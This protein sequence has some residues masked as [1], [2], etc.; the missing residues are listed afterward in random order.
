MEPGSLTLKSLL[1][2]YDERL[3]TDEKIQFK[4]KIAGKIYELWLQSV[5][6]CKGKSNEKIGIFSGSNEIDVIIQLS[7]ISNIIQLIRE[8]TDK[9]YTPESEKEK[10]KSI[11]NSS[12]IDNETNRFD[13][14]T[15][16]HK[17]DF[18]L[19][20]DKNAGIVQKERETMACLINSSS[21][22]DSSS[23][24]SSDSSSDSDSCRRKSKS[25]SKSKCVSK[26]KS[27]SKQ[28]IN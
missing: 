17:S 9:L 4:T 18:L 3:S 25:K 13:I 2:L 19:F 16:L 8:R 15:L 23:Y 20:I 1:T 14:L 28:Y 27:K 10:I 26:C 6:K 7:K 5:S 24:S 21:D 11:L 12:N 22:S